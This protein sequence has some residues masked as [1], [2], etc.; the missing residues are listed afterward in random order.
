MK[1][2]VSVIMGAYNREKYISHSIKSILNQTYKNIE[3]IIIDD[4][5]K[6][7]TLSIIKKFAKKDSRL[8]YYK[9]KVNKKVGFCLNKAISLSKGKYISI[10]DSDDIAFPD[11]IKLQVEYLEKNNF[12]DVLSSDS[13]S[14]GFTNSKRFVPNKDSLIKCTFLFSFYLINPTIIFRKNI[15]NFVNYD[16]SFY[17]SQD[18]DFFTKVALNKFIFGNYPS[19]LLKY[20]SYPPSIQFKKKGYLDGF[21]KKCQKNYLQKTFNYIFSDDELEF[22]Y[23]L[24]NNHNFM[25]FSLKRLYSWYNKLLFLNCKNNFFNPTDLKKVFLFKT[26]SIIKKSNYKILFNFKNIFYFLLII[27]W[28]VFYF[29]KLFFLKKM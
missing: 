1:P 2:L 27:S 25:N 10:M 23:S 7:N 22:H 4:C 16:T 12:I 26:L 29:I 8:K 11:K 18:Y 24:Y 20:R 13:F 28:N 15:F 17:R 19:F 5:S 3:F 21:F 9:N 6:D 14:F